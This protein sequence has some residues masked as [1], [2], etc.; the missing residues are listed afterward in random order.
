MPLEVFDRGPRI[1][2]YIAPRDHII[3]LL[4]TRGELLRGRPKLLYEPD[5]REDRHLVNRKTRNKMGRYCNANSI[6]K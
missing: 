5:P 6:K 3:G 2:L 1:G 4:N